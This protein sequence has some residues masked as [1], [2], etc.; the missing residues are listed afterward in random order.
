M[1]ISGLTA[2]F[3]LAAAAFLLW[4][5]K[6]RQKNISREYDEMQLRLR[7][8]GAWYAFYTMIF[9]MGLYMILEKTAGFA[10][11]TAAD[12]LFLGAVVSGSVNAG[13]SILHDSY[14]GMNRSGGRGRGF[15][16]LI[17]VM[18]IIAVFTLVRLAAAGAFSDLRHTIHDERILIVLCLP[19]FTTILTATLIRSLRRE[20]E[21]DE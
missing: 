7:A 6:N 21:D 3:I 1:N 19:L 17:A 13:Y 5:E 8:K 18:E 4:H 15:L 20:E 2:V 9:F 10:L 11:F 14:Y 16:L 12:A